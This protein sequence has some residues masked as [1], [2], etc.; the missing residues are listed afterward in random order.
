MHH[1]EIVFNVNSKKE[2]GLG[3]KNLLWYLDFLGMWDKLYQEK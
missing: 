2:F 3:N 1:I